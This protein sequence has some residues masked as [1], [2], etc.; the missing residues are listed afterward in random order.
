MRRA[1]PLA[2]LAIALL[3]SC[4]EGGGGE[5]AGDCEIRLNCGTSSVTISLDDPRHGELLS[6]LA[7]LVERAGPAEL[8]DLADLRE[9]D[10]GRGALEFRF[11]APRLL[12]TAAGDSLE[13]WRL[14]LYLDSWPEPDGGALFL[15]GYP[16]WQRPPWWSER[17]C[18]EIW[19]ILEG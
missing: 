2:L 6:E 19:A 5:A 16:A 4:R 18:R 3:V 15:L 13:L 10:S 7:L 11:S 12:K 14:R 17:S 1:A 9:A 8:Q